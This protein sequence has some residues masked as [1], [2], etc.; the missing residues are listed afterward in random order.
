M[1]TVLP[2]QPHQHRAARQVLLTV[3]QEL[4]GVS[5]EVVL[6]HDPL[7]DYDDIENYYFK[8][9]GTFIVALDDDRVVG[10]LGLRHWQGNICELKRLWFYK[11][12]RGQGLGRLLMERLIDL[13]AAKGYQRI[14]FEVADPEVQAPAMRLY[15]K[16]GF[17]FIEKYSDGP[18]TVFMEKVLE[19]NVSAPVLPVKQA[20]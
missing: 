8:Q 19:E 15:Q 1:I 3:C 17:Y 20:A 7:L 5:E 12:Y 16:L 18:G 2:I 6:Q 4:W 9:N 10:S 11:E 14:R 13:A